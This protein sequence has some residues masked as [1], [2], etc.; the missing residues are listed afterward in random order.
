MLRWRLLLGTLLIAVVGLLCWLDSRAAISGVWLFPLVLA[1]TLA[2]TGE[3]LWMLGDW[4]ARPVPWVVYLGNAAIVCSN[5]IGLVFPQPG[6]WSPE[7]IAVSTPQLQAFEIVGNWSAG[8]LVWAAATLALAILLAFGCEIWRYRAPGV[9]TARLAATTLV[10]AYIGLMMSFVVQLRMSAQ[11]AAGIVILLSLILTVK[12]GDIGAYTVGRLV[13]RHRMAPLLS[14]G[15]TIEGGVGAVIFACLG[16]WLSL[17]VF[18]PMAAFPQSEP[19][20][21]SQWLSYGIVIGLAGIF[22]DLAESLLKRDLGRKDS[23]PW[24]PGFG[25]VLDIIDSILLAA[26]LAFLWWLVAGLPNATLMWQMP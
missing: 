14:P 16:A 9:A 8:P 25:G 20:T 11:G 1:A 3:M 21:V 19:F 17:R 12:L 6:L 5:W 13:G 22:G 18:W 4:P 15:K 24:L 2:A 26:P 23:S 7:P 10:L